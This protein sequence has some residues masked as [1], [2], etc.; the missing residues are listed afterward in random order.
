ME[1]RSP[2]AGQS[3]HLNMNQI[4]T[5]HYYLALVQYDFKYMSSNTDS[6]ECAVK[7]WNTLVF[8]NPKFAQK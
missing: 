4:F 6:Y 3:L 2:L 5:Q 1:S 7:S 8:I